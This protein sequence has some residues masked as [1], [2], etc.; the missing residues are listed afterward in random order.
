MK[1]IILNVPEN[2]YNFFIELIKSLDF[3]KT[4]NTDFEINEEE[5]NIVRRRIKNSKPQ[6]IKSWDEVSESFR[7]K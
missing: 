5:K 4:N 7:L 3:V 6:D 2:K 1:Q